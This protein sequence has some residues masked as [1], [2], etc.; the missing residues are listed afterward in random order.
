MC[1]AHRR[2]HGSQDGAHRGVRVAAHKGHEAGQ[3]DDQLRSTRDGPPHGSRRVHTHG[4]NGE[5]VARKLVRH[6]HTHAHLARQP[7]RNEAHVGQH[8]AKHVRQDDYC[9]RRVRARG[10]WGWRPRHVRLHTPNVLHTAGGC[11]SIQRAA[12]AAAAIPRLWPLPRCARCCVRRSWRRCCRRCCRR[13]WRRCCCCRTRRRGTRRLPT[14]A[15][16]ATAGSLP[17]TCT[18][19]GAVMM[20]AC[21]TTRK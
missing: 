12:H 10:Y 14:A 2:H 20:S 21:C 17:H 16:A 7:V 15:A 11:A 18:V 1:S 13:C 3:R 6:V 5:G 19:V 4:G 9:R 8:H